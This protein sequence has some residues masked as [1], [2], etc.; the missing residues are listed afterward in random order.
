MYDNIYW[1]HTSRALQV[2]LIRAVYD[3]LVAEMLHAE[4]LVGLTDEALLDLLANERMPISSR[5]LADDLKRR[6]PYKVVLEVSPSAGS[7]F[8]RLEA[9]FWD[10]QRRRRI[11][12]KLAAELARSLEIEMADYEVLLDIPRPEKWDMDVWISFAHPPIGMKPLMKWVEATGLQSDDLARYEQHQ[13]RI[14]IV[15]VTRLRSLLLNARYD[16][17]LPILSNCL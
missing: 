1:H 7:F 4:Q 8:R 17:L 5:A 9:L 12:Q 6:C 10:A 3:A 16:A 2:M 13:R 15:V 14:R 11:E